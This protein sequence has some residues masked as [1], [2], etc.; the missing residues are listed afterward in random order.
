M[1]FPSSGP[2]RGPFGAFG[3]KVIYAHYRGPALKSGRL[4]ISPGG[5]QNKKSSNSGQ[6]AGLVGLFIKKYSKYKFDKIFLLG[7]R[8]R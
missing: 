2:S 7:E 5:L 6:N 1:R 4:Q 8:R 3:V